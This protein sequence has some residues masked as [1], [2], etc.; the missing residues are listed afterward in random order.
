MHNI[1]GKKFGKLTAVKLLRKEKLNGYRRYIWEF[2][3][4][5]GVVIERH[6]GGIVSGH[7]KSCGCLGGGKLLPRGENSFN[8][9]YKCYKYGAKKRSLDFTLEKEYFR[10]LTSANCSYCDSQPSREHLTT[11]LTRG[12]YRY[13]G[14]DRVDN[15]FGYIP[16]NCVTC[17]KICNYAKR[18]VTVEEFT[19]W[20]NRL[21]SRCGKILLTS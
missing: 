19:Q 3:C 18:N 15:N 12:K 17:C 16:E 11:Q 6:R 4:E 10:K 1:T 8:H 20:L 9:L 2:N 21:R 14:I 5:C 7:V 13:N